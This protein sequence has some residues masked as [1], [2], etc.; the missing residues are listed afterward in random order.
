MCVRSVETTQRR[1]NC[2]VHFPWHRDRGNIS[3]WIFHLNAF[4]PRHYA[5]EV[6]AGTRAPPAQIMY[7]FLNKF[8]GLYLQ[9]DAHFFAIVATKLFQSK[10][11]RNLSLFWMKIYSLSLSCTFRRRIPA[12]WHSDRSQI[13]AYDIKH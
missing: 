13:N 8:Y 2:V 6:L 9:F 7:L 4:R 5:E 1:I 3:F 11:F 12:R 10:R